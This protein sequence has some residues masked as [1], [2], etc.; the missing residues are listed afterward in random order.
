MPNVLQTGA[1]IT[2]S[3]PFLPFVKEI[4]KEIWFVLY[5]G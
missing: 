2:M 4:L 5:S 1:K 3:E